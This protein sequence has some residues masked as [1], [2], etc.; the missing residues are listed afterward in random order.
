MSKKKATLQ[1]LTI[2]QAA[3]LTEFRLKNG[4]DWK[5]KLAAG[6]MKAAYPGPLQQIRNNFGPEWLDR[7]EVQ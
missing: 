5:E 2:E 7:L 4:P 1:D 3:A 6:W